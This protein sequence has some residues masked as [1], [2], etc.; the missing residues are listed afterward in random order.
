M[1]TSFNKLK[2]HQTTVGFDAGNAECAMRN[3]WNNTSTASYYLSH[4]VSS[5]SSGV[6]LKTCDG[7]YTDSDLST[8]AGADWYGQKISTSIYYAREWDGDDWVS[9]SF[10]EFDNTTYTKEGLLYTTSSS[11]TTC[12]LA[13][14]LGYG[15]HLFVLE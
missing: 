13:V 14:L 8:P 5:G 3:R 2:S 12:S 9:G 7:I 6:N 11:S 1:I 10:T 15:N 4:Y